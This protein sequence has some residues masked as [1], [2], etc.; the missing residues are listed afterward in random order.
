M[1]NI[2]KSFLLLV[3]LLINSLALAAGREPQSLQFLSVNDFHGHIRQEAKAPGAL[4]LFTTAE[5]LT[6]KDPQGSVLIAAGDMLSG[7]LDSNEFRGRPVIEMMNAM[8][9][10]ADV[11]GNHAFDNNGK[12]ICQQARWAK[13]PFLAANIMDTQGNHAKPFI[14]SILVTRKGIKIG[15]VGLTTMETPVKATKNNMIGFVFTD[16]VKAG[17]EAIASLKKQGAQVIVLAVHMGTFQDKAGNIIGNELL[18]LLDKLNDVDVVLSAH[19]HEVV[20][21]FVN[22]RGRQVPVVQSGWSGNNIAVVTGVYDPELQKFTQAKTFIQ[23][24]ANTVARPDPKLKKR[25]DDFTN[26]IDKKYRAPLATNVRALT[27]DRWDP[28]SSCAQVLTDLMRKETGVQVV[29]YG[30]GSIRAGMPAGQIS[31]VNIM[32]IFPFNGALYTA[33]LKGSDL[34]K[35][36]EHGL[37]NKKYAFLRFSG[38]KVSGL[39]G[40]PEGQRIVELKL[41]DGSEV[42]DDQTYKIMTNKFLLGGG[43]GYAMMKNATNVV[44]IGSEVSFMKKA[45]IKQQKIDYQPDNRLTILDSL[46]TTG[47]RHHS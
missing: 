10:V 24:T 13:F 7:T 19:S 32:S 39:V 40:K 16:P 28:Y 5:D 36:V 26:A 21:G 29:L 35:A 33:D 45:I 22:V 18:P 47:V 20:S 9:F 31:M 30:G 17:N 43:D 27:N 23:S 37:D 25:L 34:R 2:I 42:K 8:G 15:I 6:K 3:L 38:L 46:E 14:P 1:R 41:A 44:M 12:V 11:S 4:K